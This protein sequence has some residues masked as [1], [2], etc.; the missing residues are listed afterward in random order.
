MVQIIYSMKWKRQLC[1]REVQH[2]GIDDSKHEQ[3]F[4]MLRSPH[5]FLHG[6]GRPHSRKWDYGLFVYIIEHYPRY[7]LQFYYFVSRKL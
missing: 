3:G 6:A 1:K 5:I 7:G 2:Y 4:G